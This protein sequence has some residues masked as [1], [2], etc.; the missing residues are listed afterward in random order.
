MSP[1]L[2]KQHKNDQQ[3]DNGGKIPCVTLLMQTTQDHMTT[4][5]P[6]K[7]RNIP[8]LKIQKILV[9]LLPQATYK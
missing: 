6:I 5:L 3:T 7:E 9:P 4:N 2:Y 1:S 8:K